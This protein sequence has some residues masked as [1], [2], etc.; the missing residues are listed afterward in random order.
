MPKLSKS[1]PDLT[2]LRRD[3]TELVTRNAVTMVQH[4]IDAVNEDGQFQAIK[5]LFEM[6]GL[7]PGVDDSS[8]PEQN[9]LAARLLQ[10]LGLQN[11][12]KGAS[13]LDSNSDQR[14]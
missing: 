10:Q 7:Y 9:S 3:I 14:D 5:Y 2:A 1:G 6:I 8:S 12:T 4:A 13:A 11:E